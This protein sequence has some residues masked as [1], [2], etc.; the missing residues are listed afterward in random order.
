M[1]GFFQLV[2]GTVFPL[3]QSYRAVSYSSHTDQESWIMYWIVITVFFMIE[4]VADIFLQSVPLYSLVKLLTVMWLALP[5]FFGASLLYR[6]MIHNYV[7]SYEPQ[8]DK[9]IATGGIHLAIILEESRK[10]AARHLKTQSTRII[11]IAGTL[12]GDLS[13]A[14]KTETLKQVATIM[15]KKNS[16]D[17]DDGDRETSSSSFVGDTIDTSTLPQ[18]RL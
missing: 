9:Q 2:F 3:F 11:N 18:I 12:L 5:P 7:E 4:F 8:I 17:A 13:E 15:A 10:S 1:F 14:A 16:A 6:H